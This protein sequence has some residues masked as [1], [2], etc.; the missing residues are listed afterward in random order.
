MPNELDNTNVIA[1]Q[2]SSISSNFLSNAS[3][4]IDLSISDAIT[5]LHGAIHTTAAISSP[6]V[7]GSVDT[8]TESEETTQHFDEAS[9]CNLGATNSAHLPIRQRAQDA[10][11]SNA[12]KRIKKRHQYIE[13]LW[14][15]CSVGDYVGIKIDKV[16]RTN[17]DPKILPSVVLEKRDDKKIKVACMFGIINQW[18]PLE[19]VVKLSAVPEQL[20]QMNKAELKEI[21]IITASK[22]F[23]RDAVNGS[24][25][26]CKG[27]C[28]TKQCA[29]K[30]NNVFCS[31]K[32]HKNGSNC[33]NQG[34]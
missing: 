11:L 33:E 19:S 10:Y 22:L 17:T 30:K 20:V 2:T 15:R 23:V 25:C 29:C 31:T 4:S 28:K 6:Q 32:C 21:S 5:P 24:T 27:A 26:S 34:H 8:N 13:G 7:N 16:D 1:A 9:T 12:D 3:N 18:W 14:S